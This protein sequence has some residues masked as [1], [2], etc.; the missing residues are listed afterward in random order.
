MP[1]LLII[2]KMGFIHKNVAHVRGVKNVQGVGGGG[3]GGS[4]EI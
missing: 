3:G 4:T 1:C 2:I